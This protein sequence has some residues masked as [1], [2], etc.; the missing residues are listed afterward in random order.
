MKMFPIHEIYSFS[1]FYWTLLRVAGYWAGSVGDLVLDLKL[2]IMKGPGSE[3]DM[4]N[5][6]KQDELVAQTWPLHVLTSMPFIHMI[7]FGFY[8]NILCFAP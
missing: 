2:S 6:H 8:Q 5:M 4:P 3:M 7:T 1:S